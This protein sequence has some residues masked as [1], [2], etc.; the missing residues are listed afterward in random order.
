[1]TDTKQAPVLDRVY[2]LREA[3]LLMGYKSLTNLTM[4]RLMKAGK[5]KAYR[6]PQSNWMVYQDDLIKAISLRMAKKEVT[7]LR[8]APKKKK[9]AAKKAAKKGG[10]A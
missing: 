6:D 8:R 7:K 3:S 2:S 10:A 1:M 5:L 9:K 4:Y